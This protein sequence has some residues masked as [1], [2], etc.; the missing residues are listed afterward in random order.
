VVVHRNRELSLRGLLADYVLIQK[1]FDLERFR[2]LVGTRCGRFRLVILE[3]RVA[4]CNALVA[5]VRP[6]VI[7]GGGD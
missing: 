1:V 7:A 3:N 2:D 6:R 4:N 5:D